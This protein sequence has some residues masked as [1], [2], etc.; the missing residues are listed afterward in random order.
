MRHMIRA[1]AQ[2]IAMS[3][4]LLPVLAMTQ[5]QPPGA[6]TVLGGAIERAGA[7]KS[8]STWTQCASSGCW[9]RMPQGQPGST[10]SP[11]V[12]GVLHF[13]GGAAL[14]AAPQLVY[15][16][17]LSFV[18]DSASVAVIASPFEVSPDHIRLAEQVSL[19]F[20]DCCNEN[21]LSQLPAARRFKLGH[22]LGAKLLVMN[23]CSSSSPAG[24]VGTLAFNNFGV[25]ESISFATAIAQQLTGRTDP[26]TAALISNAF[27]FAQQFAATQGVD[28]E[29]KPSPQELDRMIAA[30]YAAT[31]TSIWKFEQDDL[32][33]SQRLIDALPPSTPRLFAEFAGTH[34]APV[35]LDL[36]PAD[37]VRAAPLPRK[38]LG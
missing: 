35:L 6:L 7:R 29:F 30:N 14:G 27:A 25:A 26:A 20:N 31:S 10:S 9:I 8:P 12:Y 2:M 23:A 21:G 16:R 1:W 22:S 19:A 24:A 34:T 37:I 28:F 5:S 15:N 33:S 4:M 36:S 38:R 13:V 18:S 3:N 17:L 11:D 32:D